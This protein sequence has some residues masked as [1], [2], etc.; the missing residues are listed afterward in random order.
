VL[1][2]CT[3]VK[4]P[5]TGQRGVVRGG[6][7]HYPKTDLAPPHLFVVIGCRQATD[8]PHFS[9]NGRYS[10]PAHL[11][12]LH[13]GHRAVT[14]SGPPTPILGRVAAHVQGGLLTVPGQQGRNLAAHRAPCNIRNKRFL[15]IPEWLNLSECAAQVN[16]VLTPPTLLS[17]AS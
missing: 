10:V 14:C 2:T 17:L 12:V 6:G 3:G 4:M 8:S 1:P 13:T 11:T 5:H 9:P 15:G 7:D 16:V